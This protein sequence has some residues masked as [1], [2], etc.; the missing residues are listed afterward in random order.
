MKHYYK[1]P[2]YKY[3]SKTVFEMVYCLGGV[4]GPSLGGIAMDAWPRTGLPVMLSCAPL[5]LLAGLA[6][7]RAARAAR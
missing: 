4:A 3:L 1:T 6:Q 7:G 5:L 2:T